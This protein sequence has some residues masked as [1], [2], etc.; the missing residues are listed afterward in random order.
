MSLIETA[1]LEDKYTVES[2]VVFMT[3]I[4]A[5]VRLPMIQRQLDVAA[6]HNTAGFISGYR[7]SPLGGYDLALQRVQKLLTEHHIHFEPGVNEDLAATAIWGSQQVNL[8]D[9]ACY[10]GVF[11]I[12]YGKGPGVDRSGDV[13]KHANNAGTSPL[14][15]VLALAGDDHTC[16]SSTLPHQSE[17]AFIDANIPVLNPSGIQELLDYGIKGWAM[18]RFCGTWVA[19]KAM[20]ETL[21]SSAT[22]HIDPARFISGMPDMA[23][24]DGG[25]HTRWPDQPLEQE[26]RLHQWKIYAAREFGRLN[27]FNTIEFDSPNP[28]FGIAT[29]GKSWLDVLQALEDLGIDAE[30]ARDIGLRLYKIGM[31]WPLEPEGVHEFT[32]GLEE[33]LV[34]E[35]KR[36]IIENQM[37]EQL[38]NAPASQ[39]PRIIGKF[40]EASEWI[41]PSSGELT[42]ARIARVIAAR[43][44]RYHSSG[45]IRERLAFLDQ[46]ESA[47]A[48][49]SSGLQRTPYFCSGCP[50]N[51]STKV[52]EGSRALAGIGCHYMASWMGRNTET[53]TQMGG[54]GASWIGQAPFTET[55][56][57]FA[58]L[59]DGTYYHSGLLAMRAAVSAGVNITYKILVNDAVAMTGGQ[60][61]EG[62]LSIVQ[63]AHQVHAEGVTRI[64]IVSEF[65]DQYNN[66]EVLP[67]DTGIYHRDELPR[68]QLE[69]R[70]QPGTSV[71]IYDQVCAT[72]KRRRRKRGQLPDPD[73]RVFINPEVCEGCGDC[74]VQSNCL[75]VVP[76]ETPL[77]RKR[78][79]DQSACNKDFSCVQGFCP[80]FV[81]LSK[82]RLRK[83]EAEQVHFHGALPDPVLP[84]LDQPCRILITGVGGT[85]VVTVSALL[86]T[87]AW[88]DGNG[89]SVLDMTGLA[90]KFGAVTSHIQ[91]SRQTGEIKA[92]RIAA[93]G[94]DLVLGCDAVVAT[95]FDALSKFDPARTAAVVNDHRSATPEF[96]TNPDLEFPGARIES[97]VRQN[98]RQGQSDLL[99]ATRLAE[100]LLGNSIGANLMLV[101][102]ALQ[103]GYLPISLAALHRA[104]ELNGVAVEFNKR[105][106][107]LGRRL[108]V[109]RSAVLKAA[110]LEARPQKDRGKTLDDAITLRRGILVDYQNESYAGRY[111]EV[112][113]AVRAHEGRFGKQQNLSTIVAE[114]YFRLLAYKDEYE[115]AR[116]LSSVDFMSQLK[117]QFEP[118]FRLSFSMSPPLV[119]GLDE[120]SGRPKKRS[121]G[122]WMLILFRLLKHFKGLRGTRIDPFGYQADRIA[123][124]QL[125]RDYESDIRE[126]LENLD[127]YNIEAA[128][129]LLSWPE[130]IRG[131]G[132]VKQ[133]NMQIARESRRSLLASFRNP[134]AQ[135]NRAA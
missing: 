112:V 14:G 75:S 12:W 81:V 33:V 90:Q 53:F 116:L 73:R 50:H 109:D 83:P 28:R 101:G 125:I 68:L 86:G 44:G 2:G 15:G 52:P 77:G 62:G 51:T 10:D 134:A 35:E 107:D 118:G 1:S 56:H 119:S 121:F 61:V 108:V 63:I 8:F 66:P 79:I 123:E 36:A 133:K 13:F 54:E 94:A 126:V 103:R 21:D 130:G 132:P 85:G 23:L 7:G 34:V 46:K 59:G 32:A 47:L 87:A 30:E 19:M 11:S 96:I 82:A 84:D 55:R 89:A 17:F 113:K 91:I 98:T 45:R 129:A 16:K 92:V 111:L 22:V 70:E 104:I 135:V 131:F 76:L 60:Q 58:N 110:G 3:G 114:Q 5:L 117:E 43:I 74:S 48:S 27:R 41:L 49:A 128:K 57:V 80:S 106:L 65:P 124:R 4:Q 97:L 93:G 88:L 18:S 122:R 29:T 9:G 105:A 78:A 69:F 72:E 115:V 102:I 20:G 38:Y 100:T 24:P 42:P 31:P 120:I 26:Q 71:I 95:G 40:N 37:K 25:L 64:A 127:Q 6:G 67:A 99:D 39:R